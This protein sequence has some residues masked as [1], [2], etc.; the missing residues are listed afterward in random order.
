MK[1][2]LQRFFRMVTI[3]NKLLPVLIE[4]LNDLGDDG[5]L[6]NS[7]PKPVTKKYFAKTKQAK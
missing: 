3:L 6:N 1:N 5:K 4:V 2:N 7:T